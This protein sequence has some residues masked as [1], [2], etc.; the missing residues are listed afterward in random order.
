MYKLHAFLSPTLHHPPP[1]L[2]PSAISANY[3]STFLTCAAMGSGFI[4]ITA[5]R[6]TR[7][8]LFGEDEGLAS[9]ADMEAGFSGNKKNA[10]FSTSSRRRGSYRAFPL[11]SSS[12]SSSYLRSGGLR[13]DEPHPFLDSCHLCKKHLRNRD[14]FMYRGNTPFCSDECRQEQI[15]RDEA[16]EKMRDLSSKA[17]SRKEQKSSSKTNNTRDLHFRT[18]TVV[19]G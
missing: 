19:A 13:Y 18:G 2:P 4:G 17:A 6:A 15:D 1:L 14:I 12:S 8:T 10:I 9:L 16:E 7:R 3:T 5:N 11:S